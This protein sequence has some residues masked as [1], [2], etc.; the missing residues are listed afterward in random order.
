MKKEKSS[1]KIIALGTL[2]LAIPVVTFTVVE[3]IDS[4]TNNKTNSESI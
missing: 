3:K 2:T 4:N 1:K